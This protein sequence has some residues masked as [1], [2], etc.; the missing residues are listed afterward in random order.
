MF[1][2]FLEWRMNYVLVLA[3]IV[4]VIP[5]LMKNPFYFDLATQILIIAA[6]VVG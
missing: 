4:F 6:T 1:D 2:R 5:V 3:I